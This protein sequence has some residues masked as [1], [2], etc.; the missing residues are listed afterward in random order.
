[1]LAWFNSQSHPNFSILREQRMDRHKISFTDGQ[2]DVST[3]TLA[4][5]NAVPTFHYFEVAYS[6]QQQLQT[7]L[8]DSL[9]GTQLDVPPPSELEGQEGEEEKVQK[10]TFARETSIDTLEALIG[11]LFH[12]VGQ[13][14]D[15]QVMPFILGDGNTG[16]ST[17]MSLVAKMFPLGSVASLSANQEDT[18]GLQGWT[19]KRLIV[20]LDLPKNM[21]GVLAQTIWQSMISGEHVSVPR[22]GG[23]V[24]VI[25]EWKV[26]TFWVGNGLPDYTNNAG[27]VSRRLATFKFVRVVKNVDTAMA[28]KLE[29]NELVAVMIRCLHKYHMLREK[30]SGAGFWRFAPQAM[31]DARQ[32]AQ[33]STNHLANFI[34]NGD[35]F[36]DC[37]F[38]KGALTSLSTLR[39]AFANHLRFNRK[40][41]K[42]TS[43][44]HVLRV[45]GFLV[46]KV[47]VCK[48]CAAT[49]AT[50]RACGEHYHQGKNR[51]Q[52]LYVHNLRMSRKR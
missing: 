36:Y 49:P 20:C 31:V 45:R 18:F 5:A 43:D 22:K 2:L 27:S 44:F 12:A 19:N 35:D 37:V 21:K 13:Q 14:D 26:P 10:P 38:E 40:S 8:W 11:R 42:W 29:A 15:W 28:G 1:L 39:T 25:P 23:T 4:H 7:P 32:E 33:E 30:Y 17:V 50:G 34:A 16:K 9:V 51:K 48:V 6:T 46:K 24:E 52:V 41:F 47:N 3:M